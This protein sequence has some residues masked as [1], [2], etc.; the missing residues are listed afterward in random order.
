[1]IEKEGKFYTIAT[2]ELS[3]IKHLKE[4]EGITL[5][6][7]AT[8]MKSSLTGM[9][10]NLLFYLFLSF[11]SIVLIILFIAKRKAI[12]ALNFILF[13]IAMILL[14]L[15][16]IQVNI[17]HLFSIIVIVVAGI[18]Y[19]IYM[20]KENSSSTNEAILYSLLTTFSGFG[21]L[22]LSSIGAIHSIGEV[23]TLGI[24]SIFFLILLKAK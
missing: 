20:S 7:S 11:V 3:D 5:I 9:F 1:V 16:F 15:S 6:D 18:D 12:L 2:I 8:L 10:E 21:I 17:M 24:L 23:I 14:Y 13:P 19:G 4:N 22:V